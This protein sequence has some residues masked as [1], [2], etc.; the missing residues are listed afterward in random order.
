MIRD[1][2]IIGVIIM[3]VILGH[4]IIQNKLKIDSAQI[5]SALEDLKVKIEN[6]GKENLQQKVDDVNNIWKQKMESW[7]IIVDHGEIDSIE[8]AMINVKSAI[9]ANEDEQIVTQIDEAIFWVEHIEEKEK[10]NLKNI[11]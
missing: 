3:S 2:F 10:I 9:D 7:A 1:I 8:K 6:D 5:V 4:V 11:F